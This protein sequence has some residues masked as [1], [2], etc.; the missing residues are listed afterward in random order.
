MTDTMARRDAVTAFFGWE[1]HAERRSTPEPSTF[2]PDNTVPPAERPDFD[3]V[4]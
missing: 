3:P 1:R 4:A 2:E